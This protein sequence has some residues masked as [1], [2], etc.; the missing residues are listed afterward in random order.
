MKLR[1]LFEMPERIAQ[2]EVTM[3]WKSIDVQRT[4]FQSNMSN[5]M[6]LKGHPLKSGPQVAVLAYENGK[7]V[8]GMLASMANKV[9]EVSGLLVSKAARGKGVA[10]AMYETLAF[11]CG[12]AVVSDDVQTPG[13]AAIWKSLQSRYPEY[14]GVTDSEV[15]DAV[16]IAD[17]TSSDPHT[18]HFTRLVLS[19][20][21]FTRRKAVA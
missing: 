6:S 1:Q 16:A 3:P 13:G 19:P 12:I 2:Q 7:V 17:W 9:I 5:G 10:L 20:R 18:D 15:S 8:A 21:T 4:L 11:K 14:I